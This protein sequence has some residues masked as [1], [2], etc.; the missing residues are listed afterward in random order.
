MNR[1]RLQNKLVLRHFVLGS[2]SILGTIPQLPG[3]VCITS[4][5]KFIQKL[6]IGI[7]WQ[8]Q[9]L[10]EQ[11]KKVLGKEPFRSRPWGLS[12]T[13]LDEARLSL[14]LETTSLRVRGHVRK[15]HFF[16][17]VTS[18]KPRSSTSTQSQWPNTQMQVFLF[19]ALTAIIISEKNIL[20]WFTNS[21]YKMK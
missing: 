18:D 4:Y 19:H 15:L 13:A 7:T 16:S 2:S 20:R 11:R 14:L 10:I 17:R 21:Y 8:T 5:D 3:F 9:L 1:L 12:C 6:S